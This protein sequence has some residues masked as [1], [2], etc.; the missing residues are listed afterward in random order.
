MYISILGRQPALGI[1]ELERL[2]GDVTWFSDESAIINT[3]TL[4]F[5]RL[6]GSQKARD[7]NGRAAAGRPEQAHVIAGARP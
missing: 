4:D 7:Q 2:Y 6:G 1:A 5:E 3:S